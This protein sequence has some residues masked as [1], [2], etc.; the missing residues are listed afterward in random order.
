[1]G[2]PETTGFGLNLARIRD[3]EPE[4]TQILQY[5]TPGGGIFKP[6]QL[7]IIRKLGVTEEFT[8]SE[9]LVLPGNAW[10]RLIKVPL[11]GFGK[12][13][14]AMC[15]SFPAGPPNTPARFRYAF[16]ATGGLRKLGV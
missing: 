7:R 8:L 10:S 12:I 4:L 2:W 13:P 15:G 16:F 14:A 11:Q 3:Q 5:R 9:V 6:L 1:M